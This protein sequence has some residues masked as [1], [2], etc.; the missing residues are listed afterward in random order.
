[1]IDVLAILFAATGYRLRAHMAWHLSERERRE[2]YCEHT[3][4]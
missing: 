4:A 2:E 3:D 1:M